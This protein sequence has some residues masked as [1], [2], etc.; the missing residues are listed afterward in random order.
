MKRTEDFFSLYQQFAWEKDSEGMIN[1]YDEDVLVFD[2]WGDEKN[3][4]LK[5]WSRI[6]REWLG[7]LNEER[8]KVTFE[9]ISLQRSETVSF[10]TAIVR[11]QAV[12]S[13][14]QIIRGMRNRMTVG[15]VKKENEWKVIHQHTSAPI[16]ADLKAILS[17]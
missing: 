4:G 12:S 11:Y 5:E 7:S 3:A 15:L 13:D 2:M 1:L 9:E 16:D 10:A 8:V 6:I 17:E 14:N